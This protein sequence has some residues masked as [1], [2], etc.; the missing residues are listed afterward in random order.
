MYI[1]IFAYTQIPLSIKLFSKLNMQT[2]KKASLLLM[3]AFALITLGFT[4]KAD[5]YKV[6]SN[7]SKISWLG[8]KVLGEHN[9]NIALTKGEL[10]VNGKMITGGSFEIDMNSITNLDLTDAT[11][12]KKLVDH[13]KSEDFFSSADFPTAEFVITQVTPNGKEKATIKGNLTIK[14]ITKPIEFPATYSVE[15]NQVK[16]KAKIVVDRTL[17]NIRYGSNSFFD[18]LGDKAIDNNFEINIDLVAAK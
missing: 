16:A 4:A 9:G 5:D 14:G 6:D 10:K 8:K 2:M 3:M 11:Y 13:L 15:G 1:H 7:K 18:N 17:Y 12:N